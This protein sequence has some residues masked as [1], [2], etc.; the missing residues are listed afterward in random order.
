MFKRLSDIGLKSPT[1]HQYQRLTVQSAQKDEAQIIKALSAIKHDKFPND[2]ILLNYY[3]D[4]PISFG[5]NIEHIDHGIVAM[6]VHSF[7]AV[8]MMLQNT[9]FLK[10]DLLPYWAIANVLKIDREH[11]LVYLALFSYVQNT[12]ERR[13]YV[14]MTLPDMVEASFHNTQQEVPG[15]V[16]E[17]SFGGL[18]LL[19]S[20]ENILKENEKGMVTLSLPSVKLDVPGVFLKYQERDSLKRHIF[21]LKMNTKSERILSQ[22]IYQQQS[23]IMEELKHLRSK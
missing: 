1:P 11:N 10:S 12:S 15:A 3:N 7:Q 5:A 21:Q 14:R 9:T 2:L 4:M 20:H 13:M 8:S 18:V 19:A 16:R 17:I 22:F 23:K 6:T